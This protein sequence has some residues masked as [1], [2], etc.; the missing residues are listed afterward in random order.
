MRRKR[1]TGRWRRR[2][3]LRL[4]AAAIFL[5][6][7]SALAHEPAA[8]GGAVIGQADAAEAGREILAGGGNAVD[9][10]VAAA[11][12]AGVAAVNSCGIGGY[13]GHLVLAL[14]DGRVSAIDFN[15]TAPAAAREDMYPLDERGRVRGAVNAYGWLAAGVPGVLAGLQLALDQFGTRKL[16]AVIEPAIRL[17]RN[18]FVVRTS[19]VRAATTLAPAIRREPAL[20]RLILPGGQPPQ[21]GSTLKNPA[22]A[23][24]LEQLAADGSVRSFYRG[25]VAERIAAAFR[26][27]GGL[28]TADDLAAYQARVVPPLALQWNGSVIHT[29]PLTAGGLSVLQALG[30]LGALAWVTSDSARPQSEQVR[31]EALRIAWH[32]RLKL[33]GDPQATA[34][35]DERLLSR[36]HAEESAQRVRRAVASRKMVPGASDGR[37]ADGTIHLSVADRD[38]ML[39]AL[40]FT[41]GESFGA[42]VAVDELG[43]ILG[44][45]MS[46]FDPRPGHPNSPRPGRR[47][48]HNM[49]PTIVTREGRP[50]AALGATGGRRIPNTLFDVLCAM[51]GRNL[52]LAEAAKAPR[53]HTEGDGKLQLARGWPEATVAHLKAVGYDV[54]PG[55]G[56]TLQA[57]ARDASGPGWTTASP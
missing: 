12:V 35:P 50:V 55:N 25:L 31:I 49:C 48:L 39:V 21:A 27:G 11:L 15:S 8:A 24:M 26:G 17:A 10:A 1:A 36:E 40:T 45:G 20:A 56:A 13:G 2:E 22:L 44:H 23:A 34:V 30:T 52:P 51:V 53:L 3:F 47:P 19:L 28:V 18:G 9:A 29:A 32:D 4:S 43:L 16:P 57:L 41:H 33:L 42:R 38:G 6:Q 5:G 46:R 54:Q 14:P 37:T 7:T